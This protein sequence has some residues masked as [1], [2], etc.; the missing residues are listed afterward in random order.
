MQGF[1][2]AA[3]HPFSC[4][5]PFLQIGSSPLVLKLKPF[6][7]HASV[8]VPVHYGTQSKVSFYPYLGAFRLYVY[9]L[10]WYTSI[11]KNIDFI[12]FYSRGPRILLRG[13][14]VF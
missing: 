13:K 7:M 1:F 8:Y 3:F 2:S 10:P 4:I 5:P 11:P 6:G 9:L 12:L 14:D